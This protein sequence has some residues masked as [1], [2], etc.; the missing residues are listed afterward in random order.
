MLLEQ[1][2]VYESGAYTA[3]VYNVRPN[4]HMLLDTIIYSLHKRLLDQA[5][6]TRARDN[7]L[8]QAVMALN[9]STPNRL[10]TDDGF[11]EKKLLVPGGTVAI[12][13]F[14]LFHRGCRR[15]LVAPPR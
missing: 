3:G 14:G 6:D 12:L 4:P 11:A 9:S 8:S 5:P 7:R 2:G 15:G 13:S 1:G 10:P